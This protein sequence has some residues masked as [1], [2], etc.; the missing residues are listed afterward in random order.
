MVAM[1][2]SCLKYLDFSNYKGNFRVFGSAVLH[3]LSPIIFSH[4]QA[5]I[6]TSC[7][8]WDIAGPHAILKSLNND[9]EYC[10]GLPFTYTD[11]LLINRNKYLYP[12]FSG[13]AE[14]REILKTLIT[15][16]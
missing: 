1:E 4:F 12:L 6:H 5:S 2:A 13:S 14:A 7:Y 15:L 11:D 3:M 8:A 9:I 16:K 10:N